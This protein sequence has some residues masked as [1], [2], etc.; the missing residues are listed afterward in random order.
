[1]GGRR[2]EGGTCLAVGF[3]DG[4]HI[5]H[6]RILA[7]ANAVLTFVNH[8][9]SLLAP[10]EAPALLMDARER[11]SL[12]R[13]AGADEPRMVHAARFTRKFAS[14]T[15]GDF[16]AFLLDRFPGLRRVQCGGN[17][18]FGAHGAGRPRTLR[19]YGIEVKVVR[20]ARY[21]GSAVSSTRIRNA[22]AEGRV[23]D[24]NAML[25]R[26]YSV[27]GRVA[28]GKGMG[29]S[30]GY[31]TLNIEAALPLKLGAYA[32]DTPYGRGVANYGVAPTMGGMAWPAPV[33]EVH[34]PGADVP[35]RIVLTGKARIEFVKF[36]RP[37]RKFPDAASLGKQIAAD[38]RDAL[39]AV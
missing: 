39:A 16:A 8:P 2:I 30:I 20:Y 10:Q 3:F 35:R 31:P 29:R 5:G 12:L 37:E 25:G 24:A 21:L 17:W 32:V 9:L 26:R 34:L 11:I 6:Q 27:E 22:L 19:E 33:L 28:R 1:M 23:E 18:R 14:M 15:P 4:V 7:G 13:T 36:I 38:I